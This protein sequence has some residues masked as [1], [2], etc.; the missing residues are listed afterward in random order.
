MV[1]HPVSS[2]GVL[3]E[4]SLGSGALDMNSWETSRDYR[5]EGI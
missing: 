1:K 2:P 3:G 4:G 5:L